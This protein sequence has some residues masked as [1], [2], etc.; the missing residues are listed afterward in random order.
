M[1]YLTVKH[2]ET[3]IQ[4]LNKRHNMDNRI[5]NKGNLEL[6]LYKPQLFLAGKEMYPE[7]YQKV[8]VLMELINKLHPLTDGN[9]RTA[10]MAAEYMTSENGAELVLPLKAIRFSVDVAQDKDDL[11]EEEIQKWFKVH[12]ATNKNQLCAMLRER[13]AEEAAIKFLL[14]NERYEDAEKLVDYWLSFDTYPQRKAEWK[15]YIEDWKKTDGSSENK[16]ETFTISY[17]WKTIVNMAKFKE[18]EFFHEKIPIELKELDVSKLLVDSHSI[19]TLCKNEDRISKYEEKMRNNPNDF[20]ELHDQGYLLEKF[21]YYKMAVDCFKQLLELDHNNLD[22]LS[23]LGAILFLNLQN[24]NEALQYLIKITELDP[25]KSWAHGMTGFVY[26]ELSDYAQALKYFDTALRH[27]PNEEYL[28]DAKAVV[29]SELDRNDEALIN[30]DLALSLD[31]KN[32]SFLYNK[33]LCFGKIGKDDKALSLYDK[34]LSIDENFIEAII[35][36][37]AI[38][39]NGGNPEEAISYFEKALKINPNHPIALTNMSATLAMLNRHD[40]AMKFIDKAILAD[41]FYAHAFFTKGEL[42]ME[43]KN[44][45]SALIMLEKSISLDPNYKSEAQKSTLFAPIKDNIQFKKLI[46]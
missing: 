33:A 44:I 7:L 4:E 34:I 30:F 27:E 32:T 6:A 43:S 12:V 19:T 8:A 2:I 10:M 45:E 18:Q 42:L 25:S 46:T 5:V 40:E 31:P 14:K 23:H 28:L 41:P 1:K 3:I 15:K 24:P 37:G 26:S 13:V 11:M 35:N 17:K 20:D 9:K 21:G 22:V 39:S 36:K 38:I 29:L 16:L